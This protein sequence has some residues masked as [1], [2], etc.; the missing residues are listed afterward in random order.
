MQK[1]DLKISQRLIK[2]D[3]ERQRCYEKGY[4]LFIHECAAYPSK[5]IIKLLVNP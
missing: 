4:E 2:R 5:R 3:N 1:C